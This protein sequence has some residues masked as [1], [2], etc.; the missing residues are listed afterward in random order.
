MVRHSTANYRSPA[1]TGDITV[2]TGNILDKY[3]GEDGRHMIAVDCKMANQ[4]GSIL[5]TAKAEIE[6][7]KKP[8]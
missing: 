2:M 3:I 7:M 4:N 1:L 5:A 6:L 8:D